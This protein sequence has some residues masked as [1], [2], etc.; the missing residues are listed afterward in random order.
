VAVDEESGRMIRLIE[1]QRHRLSS[2]AAL[3]LDRNSMPTHK[4]LRIFSMVLLFV[5]VLLRLLLCL[6]IKFASRTKISA[7]F[8]LYCF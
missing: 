3:R 4:Q 8:P 5:T 2:T 6:G 7:V 1:L